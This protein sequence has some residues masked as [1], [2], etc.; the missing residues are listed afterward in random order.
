LFSLNRSL[1]QFDTS[2][3]I[4]P[5]GCRWVRCSR[6]G[7]LARCCPSYCTVPCC[8]VPFPSCIGTEAPV[9]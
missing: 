8:L 5:A 9:R 1:L 7:S 2:R 4:V 3:S 6:V